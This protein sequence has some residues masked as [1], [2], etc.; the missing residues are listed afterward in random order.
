MRNRLVSFVFGTMTFAVLL[1]ACGSDDPD[2]SAS[3]IAP[4]DGEAVSGAIQ[5]SMAA[6]GIEIEE[7]GEARDGAG[8]FH[9]IA[10]AGCV[11]SGEA[12]ERDND[13]VHFGKGQS[14]GAIYLAAG[15]HELCLQ[16][17]DGLH[18]ALDVTSSI[19]VDVKV[20]DIEQWCAVIGEV[21]VM[22][23]AVDSSDDEFTV[24]Q[25]GYENIRRLVDQLT[26]AIGLVDEDA[27]VDIA[28]ALGFADALVT[29][30]VDA[31][32]PAEAEQAVVPIFESI[33]DGEEFPGSEWILKTCEVDIDN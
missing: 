31:A 3:F 18:T 23:E 16:V 11:D 12:I 2:A 1:A 8:H 15:R 30:M 21:D 29:A 32:D 9:V 27:R 13:R 14:T 20:T 7:A 26:D 19:N 6:E 10:D 28:A 22:F 17:G 4:S 24:K 5:L 25:V 33:A